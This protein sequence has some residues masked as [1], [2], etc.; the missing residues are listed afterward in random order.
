MVDLMRSER[1]ST[2]G[3]PGLQELKSQGAGT[4]LS[5]SKGEL[6][7][8]EA[9]GACLRQRGDNF[10][11]G[12]KS[13]PVIHAHARDLTKEAS[14]ECQFNQSPHTA[15]TRH[16]D[17]RINPA[18]AQVFKLFRGRVFDCRRYPGVDAPIASR[19][20]A[21]CDVE[22]HFRIGSEN[23]RS[24]RRLREKHSRD[25]GGCAAESKS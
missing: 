22:G 16:L 8:E 7:M 5:P 19:E 4:G 21:E 12:S 23:P 24:Q 2:G 25:L 15:G 18:G 1:K 11:D 14:H 17:R 13:V 9:T 10:K 20:E 6:M 3:L